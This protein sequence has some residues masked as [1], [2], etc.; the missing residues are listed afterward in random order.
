MIYK[1]LTK[2]DISWAEMMLGR[3]NRSARTLFHEAV[4]SG[5]VV[6]A[7]I[8]EYEENKGI[9]SVI[10]GE[11]YYSIQISFQQ[12]VLNR[13]TIKMIEQEVRH[14]LMVRDGREIYL[15]LYGYNTFLCN[16][17]MNLGFVQDALGFEFVLSKQTDERKRDDNTQSDNEITI[18]TYE[19]EHSERYLRLLDDAFRQQNIDCGQEQDTY[20]NVY[21]AYQTE[22]MKH[23]DKDGDFFS[24]WLK[25]E[26][27]GLCFFD[28]N[29]LDTIAIA[30]KF[31]GRGYGSK[32]MDI[33]IYDRWFSKNYSELYLHT[34]FQNRKAQRLYLK[35]GFEIQGFYSENTFIE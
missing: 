31:E 16:I 7:R 29:Y 21:A 30:P 17:L 8:Y 23:A 18:R 9:V 3:I 33:C 10:R 5:N 34:Y 25:E 19:D 27:L 6:Q 26:L 4:L 15:N 11:N 12:D 2:S 22:K 32:I 14:I 20:L 28:K 35:Y 24:F 13:E 1:D